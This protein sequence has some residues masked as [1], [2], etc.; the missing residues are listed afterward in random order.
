MMQLFKVH[1]LP[2]PRLTVP[3]S[4]SRGSWNLNNSPFTEDAGSFKT[5]NCWMRKLLLPLYQEV[6]LAFG[7]KHHMNLHRLMTPLICCILRICRSCKR[8]QDSRSLRHAL[9]IP[10]RLPSIRRDPIFGFSRSLFEICTLNLKLQHSHGRVN[11][12]QSR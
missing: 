5:D 11:Q 12:L 2:Q 1:I 6:V 10:T 9:S 7:L 8:H 3:P 4:P